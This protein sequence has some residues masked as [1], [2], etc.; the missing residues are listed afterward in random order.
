VKSVLSAPHVYHQHQI[1]QSDDNKFEALYLQTDDQQRVFAKYGEILQLDVTY[2]TNNMS[3]P[4]FTLVVEDGD[5]VGQPVA[6]VLIARE[7]QVHIEQCLNYFGDANDLSGT[8]CVVLDKDMEE[9][10]AV[11][12]CWDLSVVIYYFHMLRAID[13]HLASTHMSAEQKEL[14]CL[15][16]KQM[17]NAQTEEQFDTAVQLTK[18]ELPCFYSY[19][20]VNWLPYKDS[21]SS[22]GRQLLC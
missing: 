3:Y 15:H 4:L 13:R 21:I 19:V 6:L 1:V 9:I 2:K 10:N 5:G 7:D 12:N 22:V 8:H 11:K 17:L 14:S 18:D 16:A 20:E